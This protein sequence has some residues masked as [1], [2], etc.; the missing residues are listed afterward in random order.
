M[1]GYGDRCMDHVGRLLLLLGVAA[2]PWMPVTTATEPDAPEAVAEIDVHEPEAESPIEPQVADP[3]EVDS[4]PL[5]EVAEPPEPEEPA[6]PNPAEVVEPAPPAA[7]PAGPRFDRVR[8]TIDVSGEL[9]APAGRDAVP[10]R[11]PIVVE[12][13]FDYLEMPV[14]AAEEPTVERRYA[15]AAADLRIDGELQ[16]LV[17]NDDARVVRVVLRGTTPSPHLEEGFLSREEM[18]LLETPFDPMLIDALRPTGAVA[19]GDSW[20]IGGDV[21]AGLLA[22]D[23]VE[24]GGLEATL[25]AV[26]DG[27]ATVM[28]AG[29]IDGAADGVPTH[30]TVEGSFTLPV[31]STADGPITLTG[32]V[33]SVAM[34]VRERREASHVAP[35][36]DVEARVVVARAAADPAAAQEPAAATVVAPGRRQG[37]GRP[38]L[39]WQRDAAGRYNLVHDERWRVIEDGT[40]GL[41]M[42]LVDRGALVAQ[43][44]ITALPRSSALSPPTI[45]EVE[46]DIERSL[47]GQFSRIEHASEASRSDGVRIVRVVTSGRAG[48]LPFRWIHHVLTDSAGHRLAVTCMLEEA[49]VKRFG[50]ADRDLVDGIMFPA[51]EADSTPETVGAEGPPADRAARLPTESRTP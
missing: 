48:D 5:A 9:F 20:E 8:A 17:L 41:V 40:E 4:P 39:V 18:D 28:L 36:F 22:I 23:T 26:E 46:R 27:R 49:L 32:R 24:S 6:E 7:S 29:I 45:A 42:R 34:T 10:V 47:A 50:T 51:V 13:R 21:T 30:V 15:G 35:G 44:S 25:E 38:G 16:R 2:M 31:E 14:T 11:R 1:T 3:D 43:C 12:G 37:V 19:I 33:A